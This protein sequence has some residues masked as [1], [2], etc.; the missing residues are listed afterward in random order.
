MFTAPGMW[1]DS[2]PARVNQKK[3]HEQGRI[4]TDDE[5]R[6]QETLEISLQIISLP[7]KDS[8]VP[9]DDEDAKW[10]WTKKKRKNIIQLC[11]GKKFQNIYQS[12]SSLKAVRY[13]NLKK[14]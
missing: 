4:N 8:F 2:N 1:P 12:I 6:P 7:P 3:E 11:L 9:L 13:R 5:R 10:Y 14:P